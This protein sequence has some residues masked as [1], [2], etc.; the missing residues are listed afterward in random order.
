MECIN[1]YKPWSS[2]EEEYLRANYKDKTFNEL[3]I[4]M[5]RTSDSIR[6][7]LKSLNLKK[8]NKDTRIKQAGKRGRKVQ[9]CSIFG[10]IEEGKKV[11]ARKKQ[12]K[13]LLEER[14][15]KA[16]REKKWSEEFTHSEQPIVRNN[17]TSGVRLFLLL[18]GKIK[19]TLEI[20]NESKLDSRITKLKEKYEKVEILKQQNI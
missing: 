18:N 14:K 16:A 2:L 10:F 19:T 6:K 20:S 9:A 1:K 7:Y 11:L 17:P 8:K 12:L 13:Q 3:S 4:E 15:K 5:G